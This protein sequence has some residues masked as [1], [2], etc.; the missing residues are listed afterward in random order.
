MKVGAWKTYLCANIYIYLMILTAII[1]DI[2][3]IGCAKNKIYLNQQE[4]TTVNLNYWRTEAQI[5]FEQK[6]VDCMGLVY[7]LSQELN[8][9]KVDYYVVHGWYDSHPHRWIEDINSN[10]IDIYSMYRNK[11]KYK[12]KFK[13]FICNSCKKE[14]NEI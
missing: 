7:Y 5:L 13:T 11:Y 6:H 2:N 14:L 12:V 3:I 1:I 4:K 9:K 10:I 8:K